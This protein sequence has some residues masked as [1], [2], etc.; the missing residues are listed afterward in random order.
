[1]IEG[2]V[3]RE[4]DHVR[5][6][7][8]LVD[9]GAD[10]YLWSR[11]YDRT[12]ASAMTLQSEVAS[13]V[14][15]Q[16]SVSLAAKNARLA[17]VTRDPEA[18]DLYLRAVL[19]LR[20]LGV[21]V[22]TPEAFA[23]IEDLLS[24]ALGRDPEFALAYAQRAR[25]HTLEHVSSLDVS[26]A[27]RR[28]ILGDLAA[29]RRWAPADP[30][31]IAATA[32]YR[33]AIDDF[34]G[35]VEMTQAAEAAGLREVQWLIPETRC[36]L[37]LQRVD[38]AVRVHERMLS[39][40][41]ADPL[42]LAFTMIHL[43][44][45]QRHEAAARVADLAI[46]RFPQLAHLAAQVHLA[47]DGDLAAFR[48]RLDPTLQ[49]P[50]SIPVVKNPQAVVRFF[51]LLRLEHRYDDLLTLL[52][53]TSPTASVQAD[54]AEL[55]IFGSVGQRPV[56]ELRGWAGLLAGD[57]RSA[58]QDGRIVLEFVARE[59][60]TEWNPY[61]LRLL[62]AAGYTFTG[63]KQEAL[64]AARAALELMPRSK[65]AIAWVGVGS[66]SARVMAWNGAGDEATKLLE[67]LA[68]SAP[69]MPPGLIVRDPLLTLPLAHNARFQL[70]TKRLEE[71]M[72]TLIRR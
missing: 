43:Q 23:N 3:R 8:Q 63:R 26:E 31:V 47:G 5:L 9:A 48:R 10:R 39:L 20:D 6:T 57:R 42:V 41:P 53:R 24:R 60:V 37:A 36:L 4:Q 22:W 46:A 28:A 1:V 70:L 56:A 29:A 2:T 69:G 12:L 59:H 19:G 15:S 33:F 67:T 66:L 68:D 44:I 49:P 21:I 55:E 50:A 65:N 17:P 54:T 32:Y 27:N 62:A 34:S 64:A 11:T 35:C 38:E 14:A 40:D 52:R 30:I 71:R 7:L 13:E 25:L 18:Y 72:S 58:Q 61:Y 51:Q 16:L 45:A